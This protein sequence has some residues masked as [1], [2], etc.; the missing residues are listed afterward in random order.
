MVCPLSAFSVQ[1]W[2]KMFKK[3]YALVFKTACIHVHYN[4]DDLGRK[5]FGFPKKKTAFLKDGI[6]PAEQSGQHCPGIRIGWGHIS[7]Q[8]VL[9]QLT[10]PSA[11]N[12]KELHRN[13]QHKMWVCCG[14]TEPPLPPSR[15]KYQSSISCLQKVLEVFCYFTPNKVSVGW[16]HLGRVEYNLSIHILD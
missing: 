15:Q 12:R 2:Y 10:E 8:S 13:P 7:K 9:L 4:M 16:Y 14:Q 6:L 5:I 3:L 1:F 11:C